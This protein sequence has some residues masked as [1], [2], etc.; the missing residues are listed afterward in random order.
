MYLLNSSSF[1][2]LVQFLKSFVHLPTVP[3][4]PKDVQEL[5]S[6]VSLSFV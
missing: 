3:K 4:E 2:I 5:K 1:D 6:A